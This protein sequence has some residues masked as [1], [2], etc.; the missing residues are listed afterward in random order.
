MRKYCTHIAE[1]LDID[2]MKNAAK[3]FVG[4]HDFTSFTSLKSKKKS[5]IR[6]IYSLEINKENQLIDI[7]FHGD[8]FLYNMVRIIA[9]TLIEVGAGRINADSIPEIFAKKDRSLSGPKAPYS[10]LFLYDVEY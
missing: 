8:G 10:G 5:K 3:H 4:K 9:G 2:L 1:P 7:M 6:E